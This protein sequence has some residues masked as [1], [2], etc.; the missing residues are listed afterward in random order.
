MTNRA[1][2]VSLILINSDEGNDGALDFA[3][4]RLK[5]FTFIDKEGNVDRCEV[6]FRNA[7]KKLLDDSRLRSGQNY[8][9]QWGY[10]HQMSRI[11]SMVVKSAKEASED[12][13]VV[14]KGKAV[15]LDKQRNFKQWTGVRDSDVATEIFNDYGYSG[16]M[17]DV[18]HTAASRTTITQSTSDARFLQQLARRNSFQWWIDASG[19]HFRP[20]RKEVDP[21]KWYTYRGYFEGDGEIIAPGPAIDFNFAKDV[22]KIKVRAINPHTLKEVIAEQGVEGGDAEQEYEVSL[23]KVNEVGNP[24]SIEGKRQV[25]VTRAEE[26]NIGFATQSEVNAAAEAKY[27]EI[28]NKRYKMTM[29]VLGDPLLGARTV[30]GLRNYSDSYS[31]LY[32]VKEVTHQIAPGKY[33]CELKCVRDAIGKLYLKKMK[34]IFGARNKSRDPGGDNSAQKPDELERVAVKERGPNNREE[35]RWAHRSKNNPG[36]E[37][38]RYEEDPALQALL[39]G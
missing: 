15:L 31:G 4:D 35:W 34:E 29:P 2:I 24:D 18:K 7:D 38:F 1:P 19:A 13:L 9:V 3:K 36:G 26:I 10:Q 6:T 8:L 32:Y 28:A 30:I 23:G 5:S 11:Y 21:Y 16:L 27:R 25:N 14:L 39:G 20:F 12:L 33:R 37:T 17:L 22:A